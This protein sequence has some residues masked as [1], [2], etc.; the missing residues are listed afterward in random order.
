ML[1]VRLLGGVDLRL[2]DDRVPA[3]DS[4]R[5]ESLLAYLLLHR[6]GPQQRQHLAFTLWP[7][8]TESQAR[9]N[10]RHVLHTLRRALPDADR[11]IDVGSRTLQWRREA[12]LWLDVAAFEQAI[13]EGRLEEAFG[14]YGGN[15]VEGSYD[16]WL[17]EERERL[18]E[19]HLGA[20]EQRA[21]QLEEQG[22]W[23]AAIGYAERL[24]RQDPL[25]EETCRLL[26]RLY[27]AAGDRARALRTYHVCEATLRR[28]LGIE[29]SAATR[30]TYEALLPVVSPARPAERE[31]AS[32]AVPPLTGR[33]A[34]RGRL[35]AL[36]HAAERGAAQ[37]VLV[38]GE[39]GVGKSRLVEELRSW[40]AHSGAVTAEARA[41]PAEGAMA[42]GLAAEWLRSEPI[43]TRLRRLDPGQLTELARLLP[44][45]LAE[46]P[47]L[48][49]PEPLPES[50]RRRRL[51]AALAA[52]IAA[53]G[54]PL[55]LVAD[56]LQW[57]DEQTLQFVHYLLRAEPGAKLLVA[58]TARREEIDPRDPVSELLAALQA[59]D[60]IAEIGLGR[61]DREE[62]GALAGRIVDGS[63]SEAEADRLY[64]ESEGNPLFVVEALRARRDAAAPAPG[65]MQAVIASRLAQLSEPAAELVGVAATIGREF[66][67]EVLAI[68]SGTDEREFVGG[69]DELWRR[70]LVRA[71][72]PDAYD[73]SHGKIREAAYLALSPARARHLHL[74]VAQALAGGDGGGADAVAS[75]VAAHY[76]G[77]GA[78]KDAIAWYER[79]AGHAQRLYASADAVRFLEAALE[80]ARSQPEGA[81]R[82][83]LE[84][85]LLTALPAPLVAVED[86]LSARV[87]EAHGRAL[88]LAEAL[89]VEPDAPLTRSLALA[90][91]TRGEFE[92]ARP[93]G[94]QL[95]A[96]AERDGDEVLWVESA[97]VLGI[98]AYWQGRLEE[99]RAEFEAVVRR[100]R[101]EHH[102]EHL[103]RYGQDPR[104]VCQSRLAHTLWLLGRDDEAERA[105]DE[106]LDSA[107]RSGHP[108]SRAA[109]L[110]FAAMLA[111]DQGDEEL[112]RRHAYELQ[113]DQ[114]L[115]QAWTT[116]SGAETFAAYVDLLD[117]HP[118]GLERLRRALAEAW[119]PRAVAPGVP[120]LLA[121]LLLDALT[122][123]GEP[124][125]GVAAADEALESGGGA[126]LWEAE[127]R[128][129]RAEFLAARGAPPEEVE[130]ELTRAVEVAERQGARPFELRA[131]E[132]RD[133]FRAGTL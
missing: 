69:L 74:R 48:A 126:Q 92:A 102:S 30:E 90:T 33:K 79:A 121:R 16:E 38:T 97:Y 3:L 87:I 36:W 124:D 61:L 20:L 18:R 119:P 65:K 73:F 51:F 88:V 17:L 106:A 132:S 94:E 109:A 80:L 8:S 40:C 50:E 123:A 10:L 100:Y 9:T 89:E 45:L 6:D 112:L 28:E 75:Q 96:R 23:A 114:S 11:F 12:P 67:A 60:R 81:E 82:A 47:D 26:M 125:A 43:A 98:S 113:S 32:L 77:A 1:R 31:T 25:R 83:A 133:R 101:R 21:R 116:R 29:P 42:Y 34:E 129:L 104:V 62:T 118:E 58:A 27:D 52:A 41:Y 49:G 131:R 55:M 19:L 56:D 35:T 72:G 84:L 14:A 76:E 66:T 128:R 57:C 110:V 108:Y 2:G 86:Y 95:R 85:R 54:T 68:A 117:G 5:A 59:L 4:A 64:D 91:L 122:R 105:R 127:I 37:F 130:A 99:A 63:L 13:A 46:I 107:E 120:G 70:G 39:P 78:E 53:A 71:R 15:L 103:L 22:E 24:L 93:F 115:Q 44:E 7:D 111:L